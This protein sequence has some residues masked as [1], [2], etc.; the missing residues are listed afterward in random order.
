MK[1]TLAALTVLMALGLGMV[2]AGPASA[3][4]DTVHVGSFY[5]EDATVGDGKVVVNQGDQITFVFDTKNTPHTATVDGQFDSGKKSSPQTYTTAPL[6]K[7]GTFV[8]YCTVHPEHRTTLVVQ[9]TS[10]P[11]PSPSSNTNTGSTTGGSTSG[12]STTGGSTAGG[13]TTGGSS[14]SGS[15]TGGSTTGGSTT[16]V[17]ATSTPRPVATSTAAGSTATALRSPKA[18]PTPSLAPVGDG[19]ANA[20]DLAGAP[21]ASSSLAQSL[22]RAPAVQGSWTRAVRQALLALLPMAFAGWWALRRRSSAE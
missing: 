2:L 13:S 14:T 17:K 16:T 5:F 6:L 7:A 21:V 3:G 4:V 10:A 15:T 8:L 18:G 12:G 9:S 20:R 19:V 1:H 11:S 22:G